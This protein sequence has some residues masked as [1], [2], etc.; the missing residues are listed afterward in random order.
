MPTGDPVVLAFGSNGSGLMLLASQMRWASGSRRKRCIWDRLRRDFGLADAD[1]SAPRDGNDVVGTVLLST[2]ALV[3]WLAFRR[4][5]ADCEQHKHLSM[6]WARAIEGVRDVFLQGSASAAQG[7]RPRF[8]VHGTEIQLSPD[9]TMDL[10]Q[11]AGMWPS[12][13]QEWSTFR[14]HCYSLQLG[15]WPSSNQVNAVSFLLFLDARIRESDAVP[16][17]SWLIG[18]RQAVLGIIAHTV[19]MQTL[20]SIESMT[21]NQRE[22]FQPTD[23]WGRFRQRRV[24]KAVL[25]RMKLLKRLL[26]NNGSKEAIAKAITDGVKGVASQQRAVRNQV[27]SDLAREG[28]AGAGRISIDVDG[29]T[30]GGLDTQMGTA[31]CLDSG[32]MV[33]LKPAA[34]ST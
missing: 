16:E 1:F 3:A 21:A 17:A 26:D 28:F 19:E 18:C 32:F 13:R 2:R 22:R 6:K 20:G 25:P 31:I 34:T 4:H 33:Y 5:I 9:G 10:T 7:H 24:H 11:L 12:L 8:V 14:S 23:L 29:S 15:P 27:Y 30:H